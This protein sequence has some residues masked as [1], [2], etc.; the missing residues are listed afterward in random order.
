[1]PRVRR[2]TPGELR[3]LVAYVRSLG[4]AAASAGAR[5]DAQKGKAVYQRS[6]CASCH[7]VQ[8]DGGT[9]GPELTSIG[10]QRGPDYL[11]QSVIDP[12]AVLP[13]G[14]LPVPARNLDEFL[15]V[16][17]VTRDGREVRGER[18]NEDTFTI[19]LR[20][21]NGQLYSFR[22]ADLGQI[23]KEFG[24]SLMPSFKDRL[25]A[26]E[27][28][29]LTA[30]LS[31]GPGRRENE[32]GMRSWSMVGFAR[33]ESSFRSGSLTAGS[34]RRIPIGSSWLTVPGNYQAQ[35]YS[36]LTQVDRQN[37]TQLKPALG[38]SDAERGH[39]RNFAYCR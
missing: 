24:K 22:K 31:R 28:D 29:D 34:P 17:V 20:D 12:G 21:S 25:S 15:P 5:G 11:R 39:R 23:E 1:M 19:Q 16:R 27:V 14:T 2:T 9:T 6:G 37:I 13:H 32:V 7:V 4:R 3:Q 38:V 36:A 18:I 10:S 26:S 35:R 30:Y 33:V 8:G